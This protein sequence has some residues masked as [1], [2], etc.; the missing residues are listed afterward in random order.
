MNGNDD[1][2]SRNANNEEEGIHTQ[3]METVEKTQPSVL[4]KDTMISNEEHQQ[5]DT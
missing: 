2:N 3:H 4:S 1:G 5:C